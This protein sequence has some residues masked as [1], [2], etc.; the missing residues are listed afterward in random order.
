M[1]YTG[2]PVYTHGY[3]PKSNS[4]RGIHSQVPGARVPS[5]FI[6]EDATSSFLLKKIPSCRRSRCCTGSS[7]CRAR[8]RR[9]RSAR[10]GERRPRRV[11][12]RPSRCTLPSACRAR[13][14]RCRRSPCRGTCSSAYRACRRRC[15]SARVGERRP[16]R[17]PRCTGP[18][19]CRARTGGCRR[20]HQ[21]GATEPRKF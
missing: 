4:D 13:R 11:L 1:S 14:S 2:A 9:C 21:V 15:R 12:S 19:G 6:R 20:S 17:P 18:S 10:M 3:M 5:R 16:R 7:V 8:R